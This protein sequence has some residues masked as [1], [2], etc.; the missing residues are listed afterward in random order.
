MERRASTVVPC[1]SPESKSK[2]RGQPRRSCGRRCLS[3][4]GRF[5]PIDAPSWQRWLACAQAGE[6]ASLPGSRS[7]L[8]DTH[9]HRAAPL[10]QRLRKSRRMGIQR[11]GAARGSLKLEAAAEAAAEAEAE[12]EAAEK[13][14]QVTRNPSPSVAAVM[15]T[16]AIPTPRTDGGCS[17]HPGWKQHAIR[18]L[19]VLLC[20]SSQ[21]ARDHTL[22]LCWS[23]HSSLLAIR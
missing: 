8:G 15:P 2:G 20:T 23:K 10:A 13:L 3:S 16:A 12:R 4:V 17:R 18:R 6:P 19:G 9:S 5:S 14:A 1:G 21:H 11:R 7:P 22:A